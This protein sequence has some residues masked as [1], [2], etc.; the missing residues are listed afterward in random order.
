MRHPC[1]SGFT[2]VELVVILIVTGIL[3]VAV[4][5]RFFGNEFEERGFHDGLK[6]ALQHARHMAIASR[7][8]VCVTNTNS[9][10]PAASVAV[11]MD[12]LVPEGN[13]ANAVVCAVGASTVAVDLPAALQGCAASAVNATNA[14]CAPNGVTLGGDSVIFDP[15]G[16]SVTAAKGLA[17]VVT[18]TVSNEANITVQPE[19]GW[20]Q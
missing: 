12:T 19:T 15:L 18:L 4:V 10:G 6:A 20:V 5:P 14:I 1:E 2:L 11:T 7:R 3:A 17:A 16:R 8:F 9:T 13:E